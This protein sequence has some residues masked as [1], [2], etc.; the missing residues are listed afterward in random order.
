MRLKK[1]NK[2][3]YAI[4][5]FPYFKKERGFSGLFP[6][7][8]LLAFVTCLSGTIY[9]NF[10]LKITQGA[11]LASF[12]ALVSFFLFYVLFTLFKKRYVCGYVL[13]A[14]GLS[15]LFF[16]EDIAEAAMEFGQYVMKVADGPLISTHWYDV[17]KANPQPFL[18]LIYVLFGFVCA[19]STVRRFYPE[20]ILLFAA[21]MSVPSFLSLST[22]YHG[23][24]GF[25]IAGMIGQWVVNTSSAVNMYF[26]TGSV[27]NMHTADRLYKRG[28]AK[29]PR[30]KRLSMDIHRYGR[31][32]S[33][34]FI[35]FT[36]TL[37]T[38]GI[39]SSVFPSDGAIRFDRIISSTV[40]FFQN[41]EGWGTNFFDSFSSPSYD[42]FFSA[43]SGNINLSGG[44]SPDGHHRT[45]V[46]V[47]EV[48]TEKTDKIFL[49]GD[50]GYSF[51][52]T[53][54]ESI[55]S[56]DYS[57][58]KIEHYNPESFEY[59]G[60]IPIQEVFDKYIPEIQYYVAYNSINATKSD[61]RT[62]IDLQTV[63]VNYLRNMN[64]VLFPGTP[65]IY[66]FRDNDNFTVKGD[67]VALANR[68]KINS[69][70]TGVLYPAQD[71]YACVVDTNFYYDNRI[72]D[73][74][75]DGLPVSYNEYRSYQKDYSDFV[76]QYFTDIS[77]GDSEIIN[78]FAIEATSLYDIYSSSVVPDFAIVANTSLSDSSSLLDSYVSNI[79]RTAAIAMNIMEE[80][81]SG[82]YKYSLTTDNFSGDNAPIYSFLY[83]TKSGHCAM[84]AT[85]MCLAL[86]YYGI[87]ARYVT[88]FT[89]GGDE[90]V[91]HSGGEY[92]YE[93]TD[94]DLHAWVE[95]Y[96]DGLGWLP[97]DPTPPTS[98]TAAVDPAF[99]TSATTAPVTTPPAA[100]TTTV[101]SETTT[102]STSSSETTTGVTS[103]GIESTT[104][105][106][107]GGSAGED[108]SHIVK[109]IL[110]VLA[111]LLAVF[112][113]IM[114]IMGTLKGLDRKQRHT[115]DFFKSGES[116][117]AVK[118]ML[119]FM[120]KLLSMR[121]IKRA[122][123][124]TPEAF[125]SR[126]DLSLGFSELVSAAIPVFEKSEFDKA[127]EFT[128]EEQE[129]VYNCIAEILKSTLDNMKAP[130]RLISRFKLFGRKIKQ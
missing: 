51:N 128:E 26:S 100:D 19:I 80:L 72:E 55:S 126:V 79:S 16:G 38:I 5:N 111:A 4:Y 82:K 1:K 43:D 58:I 13:A 23:S 92:I 15:W 22:S 123:G 103:D 48:I 12:S 39:V 129:T 59:E 27:Y 34:G 117:K 66:S 84:Y 87:P 45:G 67:F 9:F 102:A 106:E 18:T 81:N 56:I 62:Y 114:S 120:L 85:A 68:G 93:L 37:I 122:K 42:G 70:E 52:G 46:K 11:G 41:V 127:P 76:Y 99:T 20:P 32:L 89:V 119:D 86:R 2:P 113:V 69:M 60:K 77:G 53:G 96:F 116:D 21:V 75:F 3:S 35:M 49:R 95:V 10:L 74:L 115:L 124:E 94:S 8:A 71:P 40:E 97:Y 91:S 28:T 44:L 31:H 57:N 118:A 112:T 47:A 78:N 130:K 109:I 14:A 50:V 65:F 36:V 64:T 30:K 98:G 25:F 90:Y 105:D 125:G 108:N 63:K 33:D 61:H 17:S 104:P 110:I 121:G 6:L 88:G 7:K 24:L 29:I 107:P 73:Y 54:W 83:E 101:P